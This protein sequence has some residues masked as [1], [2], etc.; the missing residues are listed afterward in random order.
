MGLARKLEA[1]EITEQ[2]FAEQLQK[3]SPAQFDWTTPA[4]LGRLA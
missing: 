1:G 2:V 4:E 3:L